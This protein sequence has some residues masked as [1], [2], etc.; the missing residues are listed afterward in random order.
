M[1]MTNFFPFFPRAHPELY[2]FLLYRSELLLIIYFFIHLIMNQTSFFLT[3]YCLQL[4]LTLRK[5]SSCSLI[6][7]NMVLN[8]VPSLKIKLITVL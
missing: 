4:I 6:I 2:S 7:I 1:I 3:V 5:V 8:T